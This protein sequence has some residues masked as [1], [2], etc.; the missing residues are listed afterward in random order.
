MLRPAYKEFARLARKATLVP[1]V[2]S[3]AADLLTPG[4]ALYARPEPWRADHRRAWKAARAT[5]D[6]R[7]SA[8]EGTV[9]RSPPGES[10]RPAPV[11][12]GS[13]GLLRLRRGAHPRKHWRAR[14][15]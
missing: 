2:K 6:G 5:L 15:R 3:V 4:S 11:H 13:R 9:A 7:F 8:V 10:C 14:R 12:R 1:V